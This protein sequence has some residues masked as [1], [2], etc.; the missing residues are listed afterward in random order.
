MVSKKYLLVQ[1][2]IN[3]SPNSDEKTLTRMT[4]HSLNTLLSTLNGTNTEPPKEIIGLKKEKI[5]RK[6]RSKKRL[7]NEI[8][9][10]VVADVVENEVIADDDVVDEIVADE[11]VADEIVE[12][13]KKK[14]GRPMKKREIGLDIS[15]PKIIKSTA[16]SNDKSYVKEILDD[17][18]K[19]VSK[20]SSQ[21]RK[22]RNKTDDHNDK[23][24][25]IYNEIYDST[26]KLVEEQISKS[27]FPDETIYDYV[28]KNMITQKNR[29]QNL[30]Q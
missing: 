19:E 13:P 17:F 26:I 25:E 5:D 7:E 23:L 12:K 27:Y 3:R 1:Q 14:R 2:I 18:K 28:D 9:E 10:D 6:S 20:L 4:I 16:M 29:I 30:L 21:Y 24:I 15:I 11:I 22:I 8:E